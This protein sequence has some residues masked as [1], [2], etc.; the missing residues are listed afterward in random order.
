MFQSLELG[1]KLSKEDF[2]AELPALR[3]AILA[4][5]QALRASGQS[6]LIIIEGLD[7][8]GRAELLNR[9]YGWLDPRGLLTHTFWDPS[10]EE[11]ERPEFWRYWRALP[12]KGGISIHLGGWYRDLFS[13]AVFGK[14][15]DSELTLALE[16][17]HDFE[18]MLAL[19]GVIVLKFGLYL[20]EEAQRK[21]LMVEKSTPDDRWGGEGKKAALKHRAKFLEVAEQVMRQTDSHSSPWYLVESE[22]A[23][24]RDMTVGR[25]IARAMTQSTAWYQSWVSEAKVHFSQMGGGAPALPEA[26]S[27][28]VTVLDK[29]DLSKSMDKD[30]YRQKVEVLQAELA[31]L[32]WQAWKAKIPTVIVFEG[33]DAAGKGG[34]I[35]RLA[36][37]LDARLYRAVQYGAPTEEER[38]FPYLWRFWREVPRVGHIL[39]YDRS[40]Y[41]RV[42]VERV[43]KF[44]DP[45]EWSRAYREINDFESQLVHSGTVLIKFW[46]HISPEQQLARF[47]EREQT[48]YKQHKITEEDWRN[49]EKWTE[50]AHAINEMVFR[51]GTG[52]A[53]WH[54]VSAENKYAARIEVLQTVVDRLKEAIAAKAKR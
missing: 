7:G 33:W 34:A 27:A 38:K 16:Q 26:D 50:Y 10:D 30:T 48:P 32:G 51:T 47:H 42:L 15:S 45:S 20:P 12:G 29:V 28:R 8:S 23:R 54:L 13:N 4:G 5:Q 6:V 40:W 2:D 1:R 21:R 9:L 3:S 46:L 25:T 31:D 39:M 22:C 17:R 41:G 49:R 53:P 19:E 43:E 52:F 44:A 37:G 36:A 24:Y 18:R 11:L 35:R 14:M